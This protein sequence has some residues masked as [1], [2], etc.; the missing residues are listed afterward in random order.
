MRRFCCL[1]LFAIVALCAAFSSTAATVTID[2]IT[3][4]YTVSNGAA[5]L[6]GGSSSS[7]A[8]PTSTTGTLTIPSK[9]SVRGYPV[10]SIG[11]D[12]FRN[13]RG[14]T[15]VTIPD[16]V[17]SIG[18][19]AFRNC[20]GLTSVTIPDSVESIGS[21]A[22]YGCSGLM[23]VHITDIANW[24]G[25]SFGNLYGNPLLYAKNLFFN[26][27][28][29]ENLTIPDGV[30]SIGR[31]AFRGCSGLTSVTIPNSV[32]S[33]GSSAFYNCTNLTSV[34]MGNGVTIIGSG[35]FYGCGGLAD[36]TIPDG[37][38][39]IGH[40]AFDGCNVALYDITTIPDVRLVDG[41]VCGYASSLTGQLDLK[42]ARGI[43]VGAFEGCSGLTS[44]TMPDSVTSIVSD[45]FRGCSNLTSV[46]IPDSVTSIESGA[47]YGCS[48]LTSV[49]MLDSITY[50]GYAAFAGC[51]SLT[52]VT[53]PDRVEMIDQESFSGCSG[54]LSVTIG[55][56]VTCIGC[57]AFAGCSS[58]TSVMIP[59]GV[60]TIDD[61][62]FSG[63][64]GLVCVVIQDS[65]TEIGQEAFIDCCNI[66]KITI[67]QC[68][69][70]IEDTFPSSYMSITDV[71]FAEGVTIVSDFVFECSSGYDYKNLVRLA[72]PNSITDLD[73]QD[74][75][76]EYWSEDDG[77]YKTLCKNLQEITIPQIAMEGFGRFMS[78]HSKIKTVTFA[79]GIED[80]P[81]NTF[82]DSR[83]YKVIIPETVK[84]IG[85]N[86][87][88]WMQQI[89][90][91]G[92]A[93]D[94]LS[95]SN[96]STSFRAS[97]VLVPKMSQG[98]GVR[99][100]GSWN[101]MHIGYFDTISFDARGGIVDVLTMMLE[102]GMPAGALPLPRREGFSFL[103]WFTDPTGGNKVSG[104]TKIMRDATYYARWQYAGTADDESIVVETRDTY[105]TASD[106]SFLLQLTELI[107]STSALRISVSSLPTGLK[108]DSKTGTISGK[109][110]KPGVYKVTVN[111]TNATVKKPVTAEF[112]IVVPNLRSWVLPGL[113]ADTDA[114]GVVSCGVAI[115]PKLVN[116]KPEEGWTVKVA[117]LPAGLKYDA[118]TGKITGVPTKAGTFTVTFTATKKGEEKEV[119]TITLKTEALPTWATGAFTGYVEREG[120][121][122]GEQGTGN[123]YG[124]A[125]MT[126]AA[127]GKISGKIALVGTNWTFSAASFSRVEGLDDLDELEGLDEL[128]DA[129]VF[130]IE[131]VAKA[132]KATM[133]VVLRVGSGGF[134]ETALPNGV[135]DGVF[136]EGEIK[137]WRNVWK[138]KATATEAKATIEEFVGVYA[139]SVADGTGYGSGYLS[140]TV[141]KNGDV[142]VSGKLADGTKVSAT[143]PLMYDEDAG[144]FAMLYTAPSAYKGGSFAA[145]VGF[146]EAG[147]EAVA[148]RPPYQL[149]PVL[150]TPQ[151]A[152][153]NPQAT[154]VYGEGFE[155]EVE[156]SGAFYDKAK[157][158]NEHYNA[159]RFSA[160]Q[161]TLDGVEPQNGGDVEIT[162]DAKGKPV[163]DKASGLTLSFTQA[164]GIFKGGYTFV[165]D[166]KTKKKVSFEGI[167]VPGADSLRGFYLWDASSSYADPKT[168]K[169]KAFKY[170]ESHGVLLT[171]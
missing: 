128:E 126:V 161:P 6:G 34:T 52:S 43:L 163:I 84:R 164:T 9:L 101:G 165:F 49:T 8:V 80:I 98:W 21:Y 155:R 24:C 72:M 89:I 147:N 91:L 157:K 68:V 38:T 106:G 64:N 148:G 45:V 78:H 62:A 79:K 118:K 88:W 73:F 139:V 143:S 131:A 150:F 152:S 117:G 134:I 29:I 37:V 60:E 63:C 115:D 90:F 114:Y 25:I 28:V 94:Y 123:E 145:A 4:T 75:S 162:I 14:L 120:T 44:V 30:T 77:T 41:W 85:S 96:G 122:N 48:S 13:C 132:G 104:T 70:N 53:I 67:P 168:G 102:D 1:V 55:S 107:G 7:T 130:V 23:S 12:A 158:L 74:D 86:P 71:E 136:G 105:D 151:W 116:C 110:T 42:K 69:S 58:L 100:P 160:E 40:A 111:A 159:L 169:Q 82:A 137:L 154:G 59:Y 18:S 10:T 92:D 50:I 76:W 170:K 22:F 51:S 36:V 19:S 171:P 39:S 166:A 144:W 11:S 46:T 56:G 33:I 133:L 121:G 109:A 108:F 141:G 66:R 93:P 61:E 149:S 32:T 83:D 129:R 146:D 127:N 47:F 124:S 27:L 140:L 2:G 103:G 119:A 65:V 16:S 35:A 167:L 97:N 31:N 142:K 156:F 87:W 57:A 26:G 20:S 54:L 153:R 125:T 135:V 5:S 113:R 17:R 99:I 81:D 3:W 112:E 138:D 15:S 95:F